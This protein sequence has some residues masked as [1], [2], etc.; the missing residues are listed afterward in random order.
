MASATA[1]CMFVQYWLISVY[2]HS[3]VKIYKVRTN[4][5]PPLPPPPPPPTPQ[6]SLF[7][8]QWGICRH[9]WQIPSVRFVSLSCSYIFKY[10]LK[11]TCPENAVLFSFFSE[12]KND[13]SWWLSILMLDVSFWSVHVVWL[14]EYLAFRQP[15]SNT[16]FSPVHDGIYARE[17][18]HNHALH[19]VSQKFPQRCLWNGSSVCLIDDGALSSFQGRSSSASLKRFQ[20]SSYWRWPSLVLSWK[21]V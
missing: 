16:Q 11:K 7:C 19:P 8:F 12:P 4:I 21:I 3:H 20:C 17:K 14:R 10:G 6:L 1:L 13:H 2:C 9:C 18:A 15:S 5:L